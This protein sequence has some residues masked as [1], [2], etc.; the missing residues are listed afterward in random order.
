MNKES[1][2]DW[3]FENIKSHFE[4][5]GDLLEAVNMSYDIGKIKDKLR[6]KELIIAT[7]IDIKM[8]GCKLPY[9]M[10]YLAKLDK[11]TNDAE[12][13]YFRMNDKQLK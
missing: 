5:N 12:K 7:Y 10:E 6:D 3:F 2:L 13:Y 8:H 11:V 9:G 1:G 4:H